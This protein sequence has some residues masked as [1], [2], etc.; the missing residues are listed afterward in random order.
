MT[1]VIRGTKIRFF[2]TRFKLGE[3]DKQRKS[4]IS[5]KLNAAYDT[6]DIAKHIKIA[7]TPTILAGAISKSLK[8]Q[9]YR[10]KRSNRLLI[11]S[12]LGSENKI[13]LDNNN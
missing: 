12:L 4:I 3:D 5:D 1:F 13:K 2:V 7:K 8:Y 11:R 10:T 9:K 6:T